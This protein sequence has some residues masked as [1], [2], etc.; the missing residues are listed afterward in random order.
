MKIARHLVFA[1]FL[2]LALA[3]IS[4]QEAGP[5]QRRGFLFD[6]GLG[7]GAP[8]YDS[9]TESLFASLDSD[10]SITHVTVGLDLGIGYA[11]SR[12]CYLI[13]RASGLGDRYADSVDYLQM[14]LY[15]Y[16]VEGRIYP[17]GTGLFVEGGVGASRAVLQ[18]SSLGDSATDFGVGAGLGLGWEFSRKPTGWTVAVKVRVLTLEIEGNTEMGA[19]ALLSLT[20]K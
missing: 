17:F 1:S 15:L 20:K 13:L 5:E 11:V 16:S 18:T 12:N 3:S 19:M 10:P 8:S 9:G 2:F 6:L 14:N 4:A 7:L